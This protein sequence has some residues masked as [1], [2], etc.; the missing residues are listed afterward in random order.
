MG[1]QFAVIEMDRVG[2]SL[3]RDLETLDYDVSGV[4]RV[5]D[6]IQDLSLELPSARLIS[7]DATESRSYATSDSSISTG[8]G[9]DL[10]GYPG[11][12]ARDPYSQRPR[13]TAPHGAGERPAAC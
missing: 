4:D 11:R 1:K 7:A 3:V 12:R 5:E 2:A 6:L 13:N 9:C 10:R 8:G